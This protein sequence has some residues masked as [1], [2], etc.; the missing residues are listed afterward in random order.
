MGTTPHYGLNTM[1]PNA[2]FSDDGY[3]YVDADR[4]LLDV[5]AYLGAEG[6]HHT[7]AA[8]ESGTPVAPTLALS[9]SV[10]SLPGGTRLYYKVTLV[11]PSGIESAGSAEAWIDTPDV[12]A[13]PAAPS[14]I[15]E[16]GGTLQPGSFYYALSAYFPL[17]SQ[18]TNAPNVASVQVVAGSTNRIRLTFPTLPAGALG[19]N[20]YRRRPGEL[21]YFFVETV[22]SAGGS[23]VNW[24]D[25]GS[26]DSACDRR[27]PVTNQTQSTNAVDVSLGGATP[28]LPGEGWTWKVYRTL[29]NASYVNSFVH[30]VVEETEEG[31]GVTALTTVDTGGPAYASQPPTLNVVVGHP[32]K[33]LLTDGAEV[34]GQLP[35]SMVDGAVAAASYHEIV[36]QFSGPVEPQNGTGCWPCEFPLFTILGVRCTLGR[37]SVPAVDPVIGDVKVWSGATPSWN[38]IF[39][40]MGA[41]PRVLAGTQFGERVAPQFADLVEGDVIVA[42][43]LQAGGGATPTDADLVVTVYGIAS[44]FDA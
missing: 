16:P 10:G 35:A 15:V 6:H 7:G 18:E 32:A 24:I 36:F 1:G 40:S 22:P 28:A 42:D 29:T 43:I 27:R 26:T 8:G 23:P 37:D 30:H 11:D 44:G 25:D 17:Q 33:V 20:V 34:E 41:R 5:L 19:F 4:R 21:D 31:S 39:T 9:E 38:S 13:P 14:L 12:V 3:K 2:H